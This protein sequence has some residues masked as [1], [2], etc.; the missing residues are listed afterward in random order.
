MPPIQ[1]EVTTAS[2]NSGIDIL[3]VVVPMSVL[4]ISDTKYFLNKNTTI[5]HKNPMMKFALHRYSGILL[6]MLSHHAKLAISTPI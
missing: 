3:G 1:P 2:M 5:P 4:C 6:W